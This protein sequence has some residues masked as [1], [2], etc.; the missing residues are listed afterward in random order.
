MAGKVSVYNM[1]A[2]NFGNIEADATGNATV[3][4]R[5]TKIS[6]SGANSIVGRSLVVHEKADDMVTA[7]AGNSGARIAFGVIGIAKP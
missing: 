2:G 3:D 4:F 1:Q 7:P 5:S 6:L